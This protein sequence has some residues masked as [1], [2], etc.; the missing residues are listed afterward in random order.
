MAEEIL[1]CLTA[2]LNACAEVSLEIQA[3]GPD[4]LSAD[5]MRTIKEHCATLKFQSC[6]FEEKRD[7]VAAAQGSSRCTRGACKS[8]QAAALPKPN[9]CFRSRCRQV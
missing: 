7:A 8:A 3:R 2:Q 6:A 4:G 5:D 9:V 1:S